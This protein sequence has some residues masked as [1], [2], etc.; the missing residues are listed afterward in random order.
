MKYGT[1]ES[2]ITSYYFL[3]ML[4]TMPLL[5]IKFLK[6]PN[7]THWS[8]LHTMFLTLVV[9]NKRRLLIR[10]SANK[11]YA[12]LVRHTQLTLH[13]ISKKK[14]ILTKG[15]EYDEVAVK[16]SLYSVSVCATTFTH[17]RQIYMTETYTPLCAPA[18]HPI[19]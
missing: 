7:F 5:E 1:K 9:G 11:P 17:V 6:S 12:P 13:T 19:E 15:S 2:E 3:L 18:K 4:H 16:S 8:I 14:D 10:L